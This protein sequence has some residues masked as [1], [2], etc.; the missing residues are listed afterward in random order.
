MGWLAT[1]LGWKLERLGGAL[2]LKHADGGK[3]ALT[4]GAV[5]PRHG[6][7]P[8][9]LAGFHFEAEHDGIVAKGDITREL[10]SGASAHA[11]TPDADVLRWK[12]DVALPCA[13]EQVVRMGPNKGGRYLERVL[14]R[15]GQDPTLAD[16]VVIAEELND[17]GV[18]CV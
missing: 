3:V 9:A 2:R 5:P 16:S 17:D 8:L 12:L 6:V 13:T 10:A 15:P 14:H 18:V 7:A 11:E 4:L 1:R